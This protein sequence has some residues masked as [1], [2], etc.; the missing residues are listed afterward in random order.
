MYTCGTEGEQRW[1]RSVTAGRSAAAHL[2]EGLVAT[3]QGVAIHVLLEVQ[4]QVLKD[5]VQATLSMDDLDQPARTACSKKPTGDPA[6]SAMNLLPNQ[7]CRTP[8]HIDMLQLLE[9]GDL[10]YGS[11]RHP[12]LL[13]LQ[14]DLLQGDHLPV[15]Q[16]PRLVHHP[17][18]ALHP[19]SCLT[20]LKRSHVKHGTLQQRPPRL[21]CPAAHTAR[22]HIEPV[23]GQLDYAAQLQAQAANKMHHLRPQDPQCALRRPLYQE[24]K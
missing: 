1:T 13:L 2:D 15:E 20:V 10:A 4:I 21:S 3:H 19:R 7:T 23:S 17:I 8:D 14:A 18:R 22:M 9:Q 5:Q 16:V 24:A 11:G 6:S 12:L